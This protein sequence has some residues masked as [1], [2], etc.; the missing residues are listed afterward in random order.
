LGVSDAV[1]SV[2]REEDVEDE[3]VENESDEDGD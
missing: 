1:I 3:N 2:E